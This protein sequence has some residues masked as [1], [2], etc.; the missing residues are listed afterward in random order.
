MFR[1]HHPRSPLALLF[2]VLAGCQSGNPV[3]RAIADQF[4]ASGGRRVDLA[5]AVPGEWERVCILGPYSD[6]AA[7]RRTLGF[8]W[9]AEVLTGIA[10]NDGISLLVFV[11][12]GAVAGYVE[13]PRRY[14]DFTNLSG[15]C[16]PR[17]GS[18]FVQAPNPTK[19]WPSLLPED[20]A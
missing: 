4:S 15:R 10:Q 2:L 14:G 6:D 18:K 20:E 16:F 13:H 5:S 9:R 1:R 19:G 12:D 3:S 7:A 17:S 8:E 11:K